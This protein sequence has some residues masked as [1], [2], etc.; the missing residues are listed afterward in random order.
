[1]DLMLGKELKPQTE[2]GW[3]E[4]WALSFVAHNKNKNENPHPAACFQAHRASFPLQYSFALS[5]NCQFICL[6]H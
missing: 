1:M 3:T 6:Q 5:M 4:G 2:T